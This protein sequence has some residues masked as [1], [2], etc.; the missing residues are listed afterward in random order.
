M[1]RVSEINQELWVVL[2]MF[3][4]AAAL[5]FVLDAQRMVLGLYTL[6]VLYSAYVYGRR[7]AVLTAF[8]S[9]F[10]VGIVAWYDPHPFP[11]NAI[12]LPL[13]DRWFDLTVWAG[14]LIVTAYAMGTLYEHRQRYVAELRETYQ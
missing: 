6:P 4:L 1:R 11:H 8:G 7:H 3:V 13:D 2:S 14:I 12:R 5:N 10:L 9:A